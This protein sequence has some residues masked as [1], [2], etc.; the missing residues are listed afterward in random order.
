MIWAIVI[1]ILSTFNLYMEKCT[2]LYFSN[3]LSECGYAAKMTITKV[4]QTRSTKW[5]IR[6]T[7]LECGSVSLP[8]NDCLQ[9]FT[10]L[11]NRIVSFNRGAAPDP[12]MLSGLNYQICMRQEKGT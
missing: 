5:R 2:F 6:T 11:T 9:Y 12:R 8:P 3:V 4:R 7:F 1:Y 10:G